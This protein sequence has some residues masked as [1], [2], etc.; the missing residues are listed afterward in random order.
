[1]VVRNEEQKLSN[2]NDPFYVPDK[3]KAIS[4]KSAPI[5]AKVEMDLDGP[6]SVVQARK[7][8]TSDLDYWDDEKTQPKMNVVLTGTVKGV[9]RSLWAQKP[10]NLFFVLGDAQDKSKGKFGKGGKLVVEYVGAKPSDN[11][12]YNDAKQFKATYTVPAAGADD[13]DPWGS[14][15]EP[16]F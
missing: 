15:E 16:P 1:L 5:G 2:E 8:G 11:P 12:A 6:A 3:A 10:S 14:D 4:W 13:S 7:Y 9:R